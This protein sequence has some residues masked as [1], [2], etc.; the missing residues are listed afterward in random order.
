VD[1]H[2]VVIH[3]QK[4][5]RT[6]DGKGWVNR[7]SLAQ[8]R[9]LDAGSSFASRFQGERIPTLEEVFETIG[10]AHWINIELTNYLSSGDGLADRVVALVQRHNLENKVIFTSFLP[11]NINRVRRLLPQTL[12][13]L[14]TMPGALGWAGTHWHSRR[15][16]PGL[17]V[18]PYR[19]LT[20]DRINHQ[21]KQGGL[22]YTWGVN[23]PDLA[24]RLLSLGVNG[25]ITDDPLRLRG[26]IP[27]GGRP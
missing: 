2:I 26:S 18:S 10:K 20:A 9:E 19:S 25:I 16:A 22:I 17:L 8:L 23:E 7:M 15:F 5:D 14:I 27:R 3:D 6:T 12:S 24:C 1:G 11:S 21:K 13:G 4:V